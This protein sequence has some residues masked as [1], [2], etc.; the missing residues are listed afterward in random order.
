MDKLFDVHYAN[1]RSSVVMIADLDK[2]W[3]RRKKTYGFFRSAWMPYKDDLKVRLQL[4]LIAQPGNFSNW[5]KEFPNIEFAVGD[6]RLSYRLHERKLEVTV[7][8]SPQQAWRT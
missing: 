6:E 1:Q 8:L 3:G 4:A 7:S 2:G 5:A